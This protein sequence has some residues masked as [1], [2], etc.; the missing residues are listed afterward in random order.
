MTVTLTDSFGNVA[1]GYVGTVH[2][3]SSDGQ[4]VLPANYTFTAADQGKHTF[5]VTFKTT[6]SESLTVTDTTSSTLTASAN[7]TV[8]TAAQLLVFSGLGQSAAAGTAQSVTVTLTDSF[9]NVATGYVGTV[10]FTSSDGQAVLPANYTFTAA[11]QGKHTFQVT[12]KTTGSE[13]LTV[14]DTTSST[15]TA[16][17]NV[18]VTTAAQQMVISG[19]SQSATAGTA[20]SVTVTL[21]D[22]FGN[23]ATGYV[24]TVHFTSSDG[25]AVL[26]ANYTFTAADQ[27]KHTFQVTFK[28]TGTKSLTR[29]RYRKQRLD[30]ERQRHRDH[31]S[32]T[33]D[34]QRPEPIGIAGTA[35]SVTVTLTDSFGNVATGYVG[36]VHFTSTDGQAVLPANY[37]FTAADQGKHTFQV[38]FKTTG[39]ESLTVTDTA[40]STLD[41]QRQRHR[42]HRGST[43]GLQRPGPIGGCGHGTKRDRH[44]H[45]QLRQR[46]DRLCRHGPLHQQRWPGR[47]A[48]QLYFHRRRSG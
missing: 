19:L 27:G 47:A 41:G 16:S 46:R 14:T 32:S 20:Q 34:H 21:T 38:T 1:T 10:H 24:G 7:V 22:S 48:R 5:Q 6:G 31:R 8:T 40:N 17:A 29:H 9:G 18:T 42:D 30:G 28:T 4:A 2:F 26:P 25:Q 39:S 45:R 15:L 36:T 13:S 23:V 33:S 35:Q 11:D 12:F 3:T 37:T 44:P 43:I